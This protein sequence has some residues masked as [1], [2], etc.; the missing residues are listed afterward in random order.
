VVTCPHYATIHVIFKG[1]L[2]VFVGK[3]FALIFQNVGK[4]WWNEMF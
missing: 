3:S 1:K 4:R 2:L